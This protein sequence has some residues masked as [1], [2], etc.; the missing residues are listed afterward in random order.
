MTSKL[1]NYLFV[2]LISPVLGLFFGLKEHNLVLKKWVIILFITLF[3]STIV[4]QSGSD[5]A[6]YVDIVDNFYL[7]MSFD[8]FIQGLNSIINLSPEYYQRGDPYVHILSYLAGGIFQSS[9]TLFVMV[10]FI[11]GYFYTSALLKVFYKFK[12]R[13]YTFPIIFFG[14]VLVFWEGLE[15]MVT[16]RTWTGAWVLFYS[17]M[18]YFETNK[19]KYLF[20]IALTPLIHFAYFFISIPVWIVILYKSRSKIYLALYIVSFVYTI[21]A[22]SFITSVSQSSDLASGRIVAYDRGE[23]YY[24][25]LRTRQSSQKNWYV[26]LGTTLRN[27]SIHLLL[28]VFLIQG[29]YFKSMTSFETNLVS[30]AL[31]MVALANFGSFIPAVYSRTMRNAGIYVLAV[32]VML[33]IDN[34][35]YINKYARQIIDF[36]LITV[37]IFMGIF[38]LYKFIGLTYFLSA[39]LFL[40]PSLPWFLKENN[41]PVRD[42]FRIP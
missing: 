19:K 42:I 5:G 22:G 41:I 10:S 26:N 17:S 4:L 29:N 27:N 8:E 1:L 35:F 2:L 37:M 31:L 38:L 32:T 6:T 9:Q 28:L 24:S 40:N 12:I 11:Y 23:D 25:E 14:V 15:A 3:G 34:R 16:I 21:N 13:K 20:L 7:R 30:V 33:L 18:S 39:F 36:T